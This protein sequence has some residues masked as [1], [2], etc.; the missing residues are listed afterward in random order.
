MKCQYFLAEFASRSM[1]PISSEYVLQAVSKPNEV[2]MYSFLRS[3]SIVLGQP[4]TRVGTLFA[5][6][7]SA[8]KAAF[9]LES[10]PPMITIASR[11]SFLAVSAEALYCSSVSIFVRPEPMMSN[12]PVLRYSSMNLSLNST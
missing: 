7:Y 2:S 11:P 3:P 8:S 6:K 4:I 12:P 5:T 10:S 9:V 1:F